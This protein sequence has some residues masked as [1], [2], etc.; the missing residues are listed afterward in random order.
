MAIISKGHLST[1][2][3]TLFRRSVAASEHRTRHQQQQWRIGYQQQLHSIFGLKLAWEGVSTCLLPRPINRNEHYVLL[4][5]L[6]LLPLLDFLVLVMLVL[7]ATAISD[8]T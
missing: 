2:P 1:R 3:I 4:L 8:S 7:V 6:L 5:L